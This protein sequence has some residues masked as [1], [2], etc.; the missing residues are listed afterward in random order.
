MPNVAQFV[1]G[2][3]SD[4]NTAT[5]KRSQLGIRV[6]KIFGRYGHAWL[7]TTVKIFFSCIRL[8]LVIPCGRYVGGPKNLEGRGQWGPPLLIEVVSDSLETRLFPIRVITVPNLVAPFL[9]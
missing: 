7:V 4:G 8:L 9:A 2:G 1:Y 5:A 6:F 3:S